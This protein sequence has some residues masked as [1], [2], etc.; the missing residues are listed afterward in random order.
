V[1][2]GGIL[3]GT[4]ASSVSHITCL[5]LLALLLPSFPFR[6]LDKSGHGLQKYPTTRHRIAVTLKNWAGE[7]KYVLFATKGLPRPDGKIN[8]T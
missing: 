8:G 2:V 4:G 5:P 7:T 6:S 1:S 3:P